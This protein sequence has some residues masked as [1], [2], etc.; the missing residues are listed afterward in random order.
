MLDAESYGGI[1]TEGRRLLLSWWRHDDDANAWIE[2]QPEGARHRHVRVIRDYGMH[3]RE[4]A[5][6]YFSYS[7]RGATGK[8]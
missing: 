5:P 2:R 4:E 8:R 1:T 7:P 6:Q 3:S